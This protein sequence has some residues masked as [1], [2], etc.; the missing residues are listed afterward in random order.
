[1]F[2]LQYSW[3]VALAGA[4]AFAHATATAR[5]AP[6][7]PAKAAAASAVRERVHKKPSEGAGAS[8]TAVPTASTSAAGPTPAKTPTPGR[9]GIT[10]GPQAV[11]ATPSTP[12]SL[13]PPVKR[14]APRTALPVASP[15]AWPTAP[16]L[17]LTIERF[18]L[19]NGLRVILVPEP[20]VPTVAVAITYDV[21]SRDEAAGRTGFAH[22]FE[23]M[24][25]QGSAQVPRGFFDKYLSARGGTNNGTT[26]S[27]RTEYYEQLPSHELPLALW[28][29]ADRLAALE[30]TA[31]N[32]ENQRA[33]VKEEYRMSVSNRAYAVSSI[34][35][36][37]KVYA[38]Y[39]PYAHDTIGSMA[40]LDSAEFSW[41][42]A[43]HAQHY[44]PNRA[45]LAIAGALNVAEARALVEKTF[46][47]IAATAEPSPVHAKTAAPPSASRTVRQDPLAKLTRIDDGWL[48]P[49]CDDDD[50]YALEIA[51]AVLSDGESSRLERILVRERGVAI[52]VNASV[53]DRRG[54]SL[55]SVSASLATGISLARAE[56]A[57]SH[58]VDRLGTD[59]PTDAE[60][61]KALVRLEATLVHGI[62]SNLHRALALS[63]HEL[64]TGDGSTYEKDLERFFRV[65]PGDISRVVRK[66]LSPKTRVRMITEPGPAASAVIANPPVAEVAPPAQTP[67]APVAELA[68]VLEPPG[69]LEARPVP[70]PTALHATLPN[71]LQTSVVSV[72]SLPIV[73]IRL[74]V[75]SGNGE[76]KTP[77][78]AALTAELL[79]DGGTKRFG[80]SALL[81]RIEAL[82]ADLSVDVGA[83]VTT[84]SI[85]AT[86]SHWA[87]AAELLAMIVSEPALDAAEFRKIRARM[88]DEARAL[89]LSSG[90]YVASQAIA[91]TL[92]TD[93][94]RYGYFGTRASDLEKVTI[95][96]AADHWRTYFTP[97]NAKLFLGGRIPESESSAV[98]AKYFGPWTKR[99]SP[100]LLTSA[101]PVAAPPS[102][103]RVLV[104]D[105]PGSQS[106]VY[107]ARFSHERAH[108]QWPALSLA[109]GVLGGG[110]S[111]RLFS[112]IREAKSLAYSTSARAFS[113]AEGPVP[114]ALYAGTKTSS[115]RETIAAM[116]AQMELLRVRGFRPTEL[117]SMR[118]YLRD[119]DLVLLESVSAVLGE[120]VAEWR[121]GLPTGSL[122]R[123]RAAL[124]SVP[125]IE[126]RA[127]ADALF[128]A[129]FLVVVAGD[130]NAI[131]DD[132]RFF[133]PVTVVDAQ[134]GLVKASHPKRESP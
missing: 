118:R 96:A 61:L 98:M 4:L 97:S 29:E 83:D 113:R 21:G 14:E 57:L 53:D 128:A 26:N 134:S 52:G 71:G 30:V 91:H 31:A 36:E 107:I 38:N 114:F 8:K 121:L 84:F 40:D 10:A 58:E 74:V 49:A 115:T 33:V 77:A 25:F 76:G 100:A 27:D 81:E 129:P 131:V 94:S 19:A 17:G 90:R 45:I 2:R 69:P 9:Q 125:E 79:K 93:G 54:P 59:G 55:F 46:S 119:S 70:V 50:R 32:F 75:R 24:M 6:K 37:A 104:L 126:V 23:H 111:S 5:P 20:S 44:G 87:E 130:A 103:T 41:V 99:A 34:E 35:L 7:T 56:A 89:S 15:V 22:L 78:V 63:S 43:F 65:R 66:W 117:D 116:F 80:S 16:A 101:R 1:M 109:L 68:P 72:G 95:E 124:A 120:A 132:L 18:R 127:V 133:G 122:A 64:R 82:G 67:P 47:G 51:A 110:E 85:S 11:P 48:V 62:Q 105:K 42:H 60:V 92:Y 102:E 86:L 39:P 12:P 106:D 112:E 88:V 108:A 3:Y 73:E 13:T 28:L 123:E